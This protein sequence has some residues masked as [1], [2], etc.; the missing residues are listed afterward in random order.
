M[1]AMGSLTFLGNCDIM[2]WREHEGNIFVFWE[3]CPICHLGCHEMFLKKVR[4][5]QLMNTQIFTWKIPHFS[6]ASF[7]EDPSHWTTKPTIKNKKQTVPLKTKNKQ[8][9]NGWNQKIIQENI[10]QNLHSLGSILDF[11]GCK[12]G[13]SPDLSPLPSRLNMARMVNP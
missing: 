10:F 13:S 2:L 6:R 8:E 12:S 7:W 3:M 5:L 11:R 9:T 1:D 4:G